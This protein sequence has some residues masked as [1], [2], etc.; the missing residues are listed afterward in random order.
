MSEAQFRNFLRTFVDD[1]K[2]QLEF[3]HRTI[4]YAFDVDGSGELNSNEL[5]D[6]LDIFYRA[7]SIFKGDLRLPEKQVLRNKVLEQ[8]DRDHD[9]ALSYD[10]IH[11]LLSG[12]FTDQH[13][14]QQ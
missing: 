9:G 3:F 7:D 12:L 8:L 5:D 10:E 4:F 14:T 6:F 2:G 1:P 13:G 11:G